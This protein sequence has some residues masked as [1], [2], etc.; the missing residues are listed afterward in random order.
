MHT[1]TENIMP[2]IVFTTDQDDTLSKGN[3]PWRKDTPVT[4]DMEFVNTGLERAYSMGN[5]S[6][7]ATAAG[8]EL[9]DYYLHHC[10]SF[11]AKNVVLSV[12]GTSSEFYPR[13]NYKAKTKIKVND[14]DADG[15]KQY[16]KYGDVVK[17]AN[18]I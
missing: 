3:L 8:Q 1:I 2:Y 9:E 18:K 11:I 4:V 10:P 14:L 16:D 6:A 13:R 17:K 7:E 15:N 12:Q 5:L